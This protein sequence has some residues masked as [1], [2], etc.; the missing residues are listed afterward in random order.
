VDVVYRVFSAVVTQ[1]V[2]AEGVTVALEL[3]SKKRNPQGA[4]LFTNDVFRGV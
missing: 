3:I 2:I 4:K 1:D